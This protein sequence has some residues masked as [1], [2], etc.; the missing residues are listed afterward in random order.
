MKKYRVLPEYYDEWQASPD[1][2]IV[3]EDFVKQMTHPNEWNIPL[4]TLLEQLEEITE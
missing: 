3:T 1:N 4:E 2:D